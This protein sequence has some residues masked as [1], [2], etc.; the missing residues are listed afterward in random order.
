VKLLLD[1]GAAIDA[2]PHGFD[3]AGTG[4]HY[5]AMNG[6]RAIVELLLQRGA[7][8]SV[9][10]AKIGAPAAGWAAHGGHPEIAELLQ[11]AGEQR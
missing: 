5:A 6:H 2:I 11:R 1:R 9:R 8:V 10:D 4:L 7:D 3:Y